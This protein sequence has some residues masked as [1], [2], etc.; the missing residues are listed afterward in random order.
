MITELSP[1]FD[2]VMIIDDNTIDSYIISR[3]IIQNNFAKNVLHYTEAED[4]MNYLRDNQEDTSKLPQVIFVDIYMPLMSGFEFME[5]YDNLSATLK[6]H[7][8]TFIISSTIDDEDIAN[9][10]SD[11]NVV[12]FHVKPITKEFLDR[13][14]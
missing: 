1:K 7:C 10:N 14:I 3:M 8:Q 2:T 4:A 11:K 5:A 13:I 9:S 6:N 12:S